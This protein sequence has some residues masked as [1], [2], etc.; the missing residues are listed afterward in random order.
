MVSWSIRIF[1]GFFL[2]FFL[3]I[4]ESRNR[5]VHGSRRG[6]CRF[7]AQIHRAQHCANSLESGLGGSPWSWELEIVRYGNLG[8]TMIWGEPFSG[9]RLQQV[10]SFWIR[11]P[12]IASLQAF[13]FVYGSY[14]HVY[15]LDVQQ[16]AT[17]FG[18]KTG[19]W[20]MI[21]PT[22]GQPKV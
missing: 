16:H 5:P 6:L 11:D 20:W 3:I 17:E 8:T 4:A 2:L 10:A 22:G 18:K 15:V 13:W 14:Y 19:T 12:V 7:Q 1:I 9:S 21:V